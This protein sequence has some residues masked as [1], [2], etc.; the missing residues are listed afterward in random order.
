MEEGHHASG[1]ICRSAACIAG[2]KSC[3]IEHSRLIIVKNGSESTFPTVLLFY[4][5]GGQSTFSA[6]QGTVSAVGSSGR[7]LSSVSPM[8]SSEAR[9]S[10]T[11]NVPR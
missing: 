3:F 5:Y 1:G 6:L 7:Q 4:E 9:P 2:Q 10:C 8:A 11:L